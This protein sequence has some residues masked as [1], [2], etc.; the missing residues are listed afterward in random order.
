MATVKQYV[1]LG[2]YVKI[3]LSSVGSFY[4]ENEKSEFPTLIIRFDGKGIIRLNDEQVTGNVFKAWCT[5]DSAISQ[6]SVE[7]IRDT[8][9]H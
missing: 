9:N 4:V 7:P 1:T 2:S 6:M 3:E 5:L 8:E